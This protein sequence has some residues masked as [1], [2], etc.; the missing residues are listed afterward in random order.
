M[1]VLKISRVIHA[2]R[3][4]PYPPAKAT[5]KGALRKMAVISRLYFSY[6]VAAAATY[7]SYIV[8]LGHARCPAEGG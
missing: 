8:P 5:L 2:R 7:S 6:A 4:S 3:L 1:A